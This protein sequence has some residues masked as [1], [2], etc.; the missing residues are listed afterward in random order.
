MHVCVRCIVVLLLVGQG[1]YDLA[2]GGWL[3]WLGEGVLLS[4]RMSE[5]QRLHALYCHCE[6][7]PDVARCCCIP[8]RQVAQQPAVRQCDP[9]DEGK[10]LNTWNCRLVSSERPVL[11]LLPTEQTAHS[12]C[13]SVP[14]FA[15]RIEHP[16]RVTG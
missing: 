5:R 10:I 16:P 4:Q 11:A 12:T 6:H 14:L 1:I 2:L 7:C 9:A 3:R 15:V 13:Y 8:S